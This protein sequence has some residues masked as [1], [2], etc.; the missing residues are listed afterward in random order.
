MTT[1]VGGPS[2]LFSTLALDNLFYT[3]LETVMN[4][5]PI[6]K[7]YPYFYGPS[8]K[9]IKD[10]GA[11]IHF[12]PIQSYSY[13]NTEKLY[14]V[15]GKGLVGA[16]YQ[17]YDALSGRVM[18]KDFNYEDD[19][20]VKL[21]SP[22]GKQNSFA[23]NVQ[24]MDKNVQEHKA[25]RI[26]QIGGAGVYNLGAVKSKS[27]GEEEDAQAHILKASSR[28]LRTHLMKAPMTILIP[29]EGF[30][31]ADEHRTIGNV[32]RV[33]F[34]A[35]TSLD[36]TNIPID[37]KKS[38]DYLMYATKHIFSQERYNLQIT[39]AKVNDYKED[40]IPL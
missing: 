13:K 25:R 4:T 32:L 29:G 3:D 40:N 18:K 10:K 15:I 38:G 8:T 20:V 19:V 7:T 22:D 17:Y 16:E 37:T 36:T 6:N 9:V 28:A 39:L 27:F 11:E 23:P 5:A 12:M 30:L 31:I 21:S 26:T 1:S 33:L 14:D 34:M 2:F 35:N 24:M